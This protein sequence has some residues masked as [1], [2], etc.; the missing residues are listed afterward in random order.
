MAKT[1]ETRA[2]QKRKKVNLAD[3]Y[4]KIGITAV[5]AALQCKTKIVTHRHDEKRHPNQ[6]GEH[7]LI[8][9]D[10]VP[11]LVLAIS[12]YAVRADSCRLTVFIFW[13]DYL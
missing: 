5:A 7:S 12:G 4:R 2:D 13:I 6:R 8:G 11:R 1:Q 3:K 9:V 10:A